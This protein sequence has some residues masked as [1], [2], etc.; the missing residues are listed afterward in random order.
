VKTS[1]SVAPL[2]AAMPCARQKARLH[3]EQEEEVGARLF[4]LRERENRPV[5]EES[6]GGV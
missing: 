5:D 6:E 4:R 2:H 1:F 3:L